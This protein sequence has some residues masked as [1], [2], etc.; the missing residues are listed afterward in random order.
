MKP[1]LFVVAT[2]LS[3]CLSAAPT[4]QF[5]KNCSIVKQRAM[6]IEEDV[7]Y[8]QLQQAEQ[9]MHY[10]QQP[11]DEMQAKLKPHEEQM[12][13]LSV[14]AATHAKRGDVD[15]ELM[16]AQAIVAEDLSGTVEIYQK[17]IDR[18]T[19]YAK[20]LEEKANTF[21]KLILKDVD[22]ASFDQIRIQRQG[23]VAA[24]CEHGIF[25]S[26]SLTL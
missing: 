2:L 22:Q 18:V 5:L 15:E 8:Q 7:A 23:D 13:R 26:K 11:L 6:T 21:S 19:N 25:F 10:L 3:P 1:L 16:Q 12:Q 9:H 14:Q 24:S 17:D 4:I 20:V